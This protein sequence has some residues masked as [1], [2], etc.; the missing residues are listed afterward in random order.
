MSVI[1]APLS[2]KTKLLYG[3]GSIAYGVKGQLMSL[4]LLF[5]NQMVGLPPEMVSTVLMI[6]VVL[7]AIWDPLIGQYSDNL[8][9]PLGRRHTLMY[10]SAIPAAVTFVM[11][12]HPPAGWS[13]MALCGYLLA[14]VMLTRLTISFYE[15]P[16]TALAPELAPQYHERTSLLAYRYMFGTLGTAGAAIMAYGIFLK[17]TPEQPM[18]QLNAA[19]YPPYAITVAIIMTASIL[20]STAATHHRIKGLHTPPDR[21]LGLRAMVREIGATLNNRN[22]LVAIVASGFV[23]VAIGL[24]SGLH[25]Y[26][27]TYFWEL[28]SSKLLILTLSSV[29]AAP[30]AAIYAPR[31]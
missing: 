18:G 28:P 2:L 27:A 24:I 3:L 17:S 31:L 29:A 15:I 25:I 10:A 4:L 19:G 22:F 6:S 23:G 13:D 21:K 7:D 5:Y 1:Q 16:S 14:L 12:W 8:R 9:S 20:I 26:F 11:L 30:I